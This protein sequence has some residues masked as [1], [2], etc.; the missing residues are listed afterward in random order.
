MNAD[1]CSNGTVTVTNSTEDISSNDTAAAVQLRIVQPEHGGGSCNCWGLDEVSINEHSI[2]LDRGELYTS[3]ACMHAA[4][5]VT[6][7]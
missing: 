1:G 5:Y 7:L 4:V 2:T 3:H 6:Y